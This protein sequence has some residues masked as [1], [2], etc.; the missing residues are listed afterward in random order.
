MPFDLMMRAGLVEPGRLDVVAPRRDRRDAVLQAR[1]DAVLQAEL[2]AHGRE[3]DREAVGFHE[4]CSVCS[5][6]RL[7]ERVGERALVIAAKS[8]IG[9]TAR[10]G[11]SSDPSAIAPSRIVTRTRP[12]AAR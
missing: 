3:I 6:S 2:L 4:L 12:F 7:R 10:P 1:L 9:P 11:V 5:L 8:G